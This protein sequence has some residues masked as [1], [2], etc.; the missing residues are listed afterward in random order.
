[1]AWRA[2][3]DSAPCT[4]V[5][6][7]M[8]NPLLVGPPPR[9]SRSPCGGARPSPIA[10]LRLTFNACCLNSVREFSAEDGEA[11]S[12]ALSRLGISSLPLSGWPGDGEAEPRSC[13]SP[14]ILTFYFGNYIIAASVVSSIFCLSA[15][16]P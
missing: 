4:R 14:P 16:L 5:S 10:E 15:G 12:T 9:V 13:F 6:G 2:T 11:F 1:M 7:D 8:R 3:I